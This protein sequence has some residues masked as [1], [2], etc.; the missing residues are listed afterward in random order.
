MLNCSTPWY[1]ICIIW[2]NTS[3]GDPHGLAQEHDLLERTNGHEQ[4]QL[5]YLQSRAPPRCPCK[6]RIVDIPVLPQYACNFLLVRIIHNLLIYPFAYIFIRTFF[7][8]D[9]LFKWVLI[10]TIST[11]SPSLLTPFPI[12]L[13]VIRPGYSSPYAGSHCGKSHILVCCKDS[14]GLWISAV[15]H[16]FT[17]AMILVMVERSLWILSAISFFAWQLKCIF[18]NEK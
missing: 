5:P 7:L 13:P 2:M 16:F 4:Q 18:S 11:F 17:L 1:S 12:Y 10:S 14:G 8:Y 9:I 6:H 15:L 3:I